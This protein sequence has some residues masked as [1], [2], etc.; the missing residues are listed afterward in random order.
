MQSV[1][2]I[3]SPLSPD[4]RAGVAGRLRTLINNPERLEPGAAARRLGVSEVALR[5]SID[6]ESPRPTT[7]VLVAAIRYYGVDP[8]WLLTGE[9]DAALH[10]QAI[11]GDRD[12]TA[13]VVSDVVHRRN[14]PP[15]TPSIRVFPSAADQSTDG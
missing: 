1:L 14:T 3:S 4:D 6:G 10:R 13:A 7:E 12:A 15:G 8:S 11:E 5:M 9:Y 2:D